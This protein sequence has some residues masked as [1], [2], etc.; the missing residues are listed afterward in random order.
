MEKLK[1]W[2]INNLLPIIQG[3]ITGLSYVIKIII[4]GWH[5]TITEI[6]LLSLTTVAFIIVLSKYLWDKFSYR[7]Y[8]YPWSKIRSNYIIENKHI[9]YT[10]KNSNAHYSRELTVKCQTNHLDSILDKYI[11]TG[12]VEPWPLRPVRNIKELKMEAR[13]GVWKYFRVVFDHIINKGDTITVGY[14]WPNIIDCKSSSPFFSTTTEEPTKNIIMSLNLGSSYSGATIYLEEYRSM[15]SDYQIK[16]VQEKL[17]D[18][19][20]YQWNIRKPKRFRYY[21]IRWAWNT[22]DT[23]PILP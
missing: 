11:W 5:W 19:G 1:T 14:E 4:T 6:I 9:K 21:L 17:D 3:T 22:N 18:N 2:L 16:V 15:G 20:Y 8:C 7:A 12:K 23:P 13:I 10:A